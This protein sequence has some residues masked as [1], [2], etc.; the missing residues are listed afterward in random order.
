VLNGRRKGLP[1]KELSAFIAKDRGMRVNTC[2][3]YNST[4]VLI[5]QMGICLMGEM[6]EPRIML[7]KRMKGD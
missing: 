7:I 3:G 4:N 6:Y 5:F 1:Y 2:D